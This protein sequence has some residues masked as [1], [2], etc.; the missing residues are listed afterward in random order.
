MST[1]YSNKSFVLTAEKKIRFG[2]IL[3]QF[4]YLILIRG[5]QRS[6]WSGNH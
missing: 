2:V 3:L 6:S 5:Q 4:D 1:K